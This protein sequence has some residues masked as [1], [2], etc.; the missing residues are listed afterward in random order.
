MPYAASTLNQNAVNL[1]K[2][3]RQ[4]LLRSAQLAT[5]EE[6]LEEAKIITTDDELPSE[7]INEINS[8]AQ[9]NIIEA[10]Q[11]WKE[12]NNRRSAEVKNLRDYAAS[13]PPLTVQPNFDTARTIIRNYGNTASQAITQIAFSVLA[14]EASKDN[15]F[16]ESTKAFQDNV[17]VLTVEVAYIGTLTKNVEIQATTPTPPK[18]AKKSPAPA[19]S[20]YR[21]LPAVPPVAA[22]RATAVIR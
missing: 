11:L 22:A 8:I 19:P 3:N 6:G 1:Q 18:N 2:L 16:Q 12:A 10:R 14:Y 21:A 15:N 4:Y 20:P 13:Q 7:I 17:T 9:E 5:A